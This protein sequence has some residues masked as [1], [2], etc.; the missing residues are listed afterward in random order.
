[1]IITKSVTRFAR[2]TVDSIQTI[3]RLKELC[4][5]VIFEK[6]HINSL[7]EKSEQMLTILSSVAQGEAESIS[8]NIKW[9]VVKRFRDG[10]VTLSEPAYGYIK[11]EN[12]ELIIKEEEAAL[13]RRI[14]REYLNIPTIRSAEKWND[15]V[16]KEIL[17]NAVGMA[18]L[19]Y[20]SN[21]II[22]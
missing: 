17:Q 3:R 6:E 19:D 16:I 14:F 22:I 11:D 9:A 2:N 10:T 1:M 13:I 15:G 7:S 20:A 21:D 4:I 12:G 5:A 8:T 18:K